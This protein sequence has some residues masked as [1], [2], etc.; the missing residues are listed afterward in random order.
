MFIPFNWPWPDRTR[1]EGADAAPALE[2]IRRAP[3]DQ[4]FR[5]PL[6]FVHGAYVGA[7][8]WDVHFLPWFA[9]RGFGVQAVSLRGH[10]ASAGE[11]NRAGIADFV[12]D[13][14]RVVVELDAPPVLIG[15]SMGG[16]VI[17]KYLERYSARAAVLMASVPPTGLLRS[18]LRLLM[19]D[20]MLMTQL[21]LVQNRGPQSAD[22]KI[23][24]RA[25][26]SDHLPAEELARYSARMQRE[27][28]R[29]LWDMTAGLL[30]RP[31]RVDERMPMLVIGAAEDALFPVAESRAT[32]TAYGADLHIEPDMAHAMMLEPGWR[33]V[34]ERLVQWLL[35]NGVG[36]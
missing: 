17:Q 25:V 3:R 4:V 34:A 31:W 15:H 2:I 21:G 33:G 6:V 11:L 18:T 36:R 9:E 22:M 5:T 7:W 35:D 29:A 32:A 16:L 19:S 13:L 20:P 14:H 24:R 28:Q 12:D 26:F 8:C 23:A 27:S 30:P 10:G 1:E